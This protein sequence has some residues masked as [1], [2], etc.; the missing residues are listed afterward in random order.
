MATTYCTR[1]N[2]VSIIGAPALLACIDDNQD[3]VESPSESQHIA[4]A[5]TR[6]AVE[7]NESLRCQYVL[8]DL[9]NNDWCR[10]CN[11]HLA[12]MFLFSRRGNPAPA[13]VLEQVNTYRERLAE[14]RWGRFQVPEVNPSADHTPTVSN[15]Q[16][17]LGKIDMPV[18]VDTAEST[19]L[20]PEGNRKRE[21][22]KQPGWWS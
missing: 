18:R 19:G 13:Q 9:N 22:A 7:M 17:E 8:T 20:A 15:F 6:A 5:I 1:L 16:T 11:A 21:T 10:W 2:I 14:I 12:A 3:G 4:D